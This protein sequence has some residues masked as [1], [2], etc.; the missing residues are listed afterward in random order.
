MSY[1]TFLPLAIIM[2]FAVVTV[3]FLPRLTKERRN[4]LLAFCAGYI[5]HA[6]IK[7]LIT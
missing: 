5:V 2:V 1:L 4:L 7:A 3:A 6:A